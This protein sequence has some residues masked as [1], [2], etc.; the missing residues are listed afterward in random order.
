[1][2][3]WRAGGLADAIAAEEIMDIDA[4][5]EMDLSVPQTEASQDKLLSVTPSLL[6][7]S[8][9]VLDFSAEPTKNSTKKSEVLSNSVFGKLTT[10][11]TNINIF[12]FLSAEELANVGIVNKAWKN[13]TSDEALWGY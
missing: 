5:G 10:K 1:M 11:S 3:W 12:S 2:G 8:A 6:S 9:E 4:G 13:V 7:E